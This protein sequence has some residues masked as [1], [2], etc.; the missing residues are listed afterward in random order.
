MRA[1][2]QGRLQPQNGSHTDYGYLLI[3]AHLMHIFNGSC[4]EGALIATRLPAEQIYAGSL[5]PG[6]C[7]CSV[8]GP[9]FSRGGPR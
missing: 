9:C 3:F 5:C 4:I 7:E 2:I 8:H 1:H 6:V